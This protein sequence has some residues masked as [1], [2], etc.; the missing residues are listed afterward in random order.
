M[1]DKEPPATITVPVDP[2]NPGEFFACCGLLELAHRLSR[3]ESR[4]VGWFDESNGSRFQFSVSAYATTGELRLVNVI[5]ALR[6][7]PLS[8]TPHSK[9]GPVRI[10]AP[11]SI[12]ID[13]RPP[14][15]QNGIIKTFAGQQNLLEI[16]QALQH[17]VRGIHSDD[18]TCSN[19]LRIRA[20]TNKEVT[21]F[22]IEKAENA[23][24]AGF[25]MDQQKK[26]LFR[27]SLVFLELLALIG[28]QRFCPRQGE[29]RLSREY[30]TWQ[31]PLPA[32]LA[33]IAVSSLIPGIHQRGFVFQMYKRDPE[34]RYKGF[35]PARNN[36]K[37]KGEIA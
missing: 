3:K 2:Y 18:V 12:T 33:A 11:L 19:I 10:G 4:A 15:P 22:G 17:A 16:L 32:P 1:S 8:T 37:M 29:D 14:F 6:N 21:A 7:C 13:W 30:Y 31:E 34:G 9:E 28:T 20:K 24:D 35:A 23:I 27:Q 26:R 5:E 36:S 25:S